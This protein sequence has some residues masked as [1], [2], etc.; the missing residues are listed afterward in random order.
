M[1][2]ATNGRRPPSLQGDHASAPHG[3][4]KSGRLRHGS[5]ARSL[6]ASTAEV[7]RMAQRS[8]TTA[9]VALQRRRR[10]ADR[11]NHSE[12]GTNIPKQTLTPGMGLRT[13]PLTPLDDRDWAKDSGDEARSH[14]YGPTSNRTM[15][16]GS[17]LMLDVAVSLDP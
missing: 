16:V 4:L 7:S 10:C 12:T 13:Q 9:A 11:S 8:R 6:A 1:R 17:H 2:E 3:C 15:C 14:R 5:S